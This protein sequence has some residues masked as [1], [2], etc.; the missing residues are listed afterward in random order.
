M[1]HHLLAL[2]TWDNAYCNKHIL[3]IEHVADKFLERMLLTER[4]QTQ[5]QDGIIKILVWKNDSSLD[6]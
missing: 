2:L 4:A 1:T 5:N 6:S 3:D